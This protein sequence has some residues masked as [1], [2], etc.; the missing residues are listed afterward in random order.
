VGVGVGVDEGASVS[1]GVTPGGRVEVVVALSVEIGLVQE[2][3]RN[4]NRI[5]VS[6]L[7]NMAML[8][9]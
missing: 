2:V 7:G 1:E 5:P 9:I 3:S 4:T 8:I 6:C